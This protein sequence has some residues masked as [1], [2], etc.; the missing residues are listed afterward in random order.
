M[1][2]EPF[3]VGVVGHRRLDPRAET[4]VRASCSDLLRR[5]AVTHGP[6]VAVSAIAEGAD[7]L[8]AEAAIE[9][10]VPLA[11]VRPFAD[12][13]GDFDGPARDRYDRLRD[14]AHVETRLPFDARSDD[15]Y[16]AAMRTIIGGVHL[17]VAVWDGQPAGGQGGT[18]AAVA[19]TMGRAAPWIHVDPN[20]RTVR[21]H[22]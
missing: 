2:A 11:V 6:L 1:P 4:F 7:T 13:R 22:S 16:A 12:Y 5:L 3:R 20:R 14:A 21:D 18:W 10:G 19:D 15:A 8:F 9:L 17:L